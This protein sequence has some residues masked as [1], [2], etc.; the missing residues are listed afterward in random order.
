MPRI[1]L[2]RGV[3]MF[4]S[5]RGGIH[6]ADSKNI[7]QNCSIELGP[8]PK[9][10]VIPLRQHIGAIATPVVK[11]G[12]VVKKGQL[13]GHREGF[14]S[15]NIHSSICGTVVDV[16][17][18]NH[19]T[20]GKCLSVIIESNGEDEWYEGIPAKR[21][22]DNLTSKD[23]KE[24]VQSMGIVGL[25]GA[26][27][28]THVKLSPGDTKVIDTLILNGAECEPYLTADYRIM[29]EWADK[30]IEGTI[31]TMKML[32]VQKTYIGIE[33][34]KPE[35]IEKMKQAVKYNNNC[36][37][38]D[39]LSIEV[40]ALPTKYPQGAEKMLIKVLT[41]REVPSGGLPTDVKVVVQN[42][43]TISAIYDAVVNGIPLVERVVTVSGGAIKE[44][45][46]L[47]LRVGT[48]FEDAMNL[49]GGIN[50]EAKKIIMGGPMMGFA[51]YTLDIPIV[52]GTSGIL[53]LTEK[54]VNQNKEYPCIRCGKCVEVCPMG[55]VPSMFA[56][57]AENDAYLEAKE[58]YSLLDCVECGSCAYICPAKR[59][60]VQLIRYNKLQCTLATNKK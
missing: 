58:D 51:Q 34:N 17:E 36:N 11:K 3:E 30:V 1:L 20:F 37:N 18:Y 35:A 21:N 41:G 46:N 22:I 57:L 26:T 45:K 39:G 54:E 10:V 27:F 47:L 15:S 23:M 49:C 32:N 52:K 28:P 56:T 60:I 53:A 6:P 50:E 12:D 19:G 31:I 38:E 42:V 16:C 48:T 14:V 7:S 25:G 24:I 8:I 4:K 40:V 55:L 33:D 43:G 13:I 2:K 44:P 5:F 29:V 9:K 59:K